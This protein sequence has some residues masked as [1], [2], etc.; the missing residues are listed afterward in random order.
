MDSTGGILVHKDGGGF[1]SFLPRALTTIFAS[2]VGPRSQKENGHREGV[3][4][5]LCCVLAGY[6][7][8][9]GWVFIFERR[10]AAVP[11]QH[12]GSTPPASARHPAGSGALRLV[13]ERRAARQFFR[14]SAFAEL[15]TTA[16][17][18]TVG[19]VSSSQFGRS[20]R[21]SRVHAESRAGGARQAR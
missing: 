13:L 20:L 21:R 14:P 12:T 6:R 7:R 9:L 19:R 17:L 3:E 4:N 18:R 11:V 16:K 1:A 2:C 15:P 10:L 8:V 5:G